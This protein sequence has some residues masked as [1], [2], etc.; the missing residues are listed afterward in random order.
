MPTSATCA[1]ERVAD[2]GELDILLDPAR[3]AGLD[4]PAAQRGTTDEA[5]GFE[6]LSDV[7]PDVA[8]VLEPIRT[9]Y[10]TGA[11]DADGF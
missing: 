5:G 8:D 4:E 6:T 2:G 11:P 3:L 9:V 10:G 1:R 7:G